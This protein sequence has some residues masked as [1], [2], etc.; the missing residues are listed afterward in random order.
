[1]AGLVAPE[2]DR[3]LPAVM[4]VRLG[5]LRHHV[6]LEDRAA[7]R[8]DGELSVLADPEE[9]AEEARVV[10]VELGAPDDPLA[11]VSRVRPE[12]EDDEARLED[13]DPPAR[14]VHR[15][16]AVGGEGGVVEDL[17]R[18]AGAE[19][20]EPLEGRRSPT[21]TNAADVALD[22]GLQVVGQPDLR[23]DPAVVDARVEA[24]AQLGKSSRRVVRWSK[25]DAGRT[26]RF[27]FWPSS[28]HRESGSRW[29]ISV[30]PARLWETCS[31]RRRFWEPVSTNRPGVGPR[32]RRSARRRAGPGRAALRRG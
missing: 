32:R 5:D 10:E 30:R 2:E 31:T 13:G 24:G 18:A 4:E 28:S 27:A 9:V 1:M 8:V 25:S 11:E 19:R 26:G 6:V 16:A 29:R 23:R 7:Q 20:E 3:W 17:A 14:S 15:H 22:V 21:L 12:Q